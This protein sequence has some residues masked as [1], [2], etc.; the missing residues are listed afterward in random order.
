MTQPLEQACDSGRIEQYLNEQLS[1]PDQVEFEAHLSQ[2]A[3]CQ[4]QIERR[5]AEPELWENAAALLAQS[6]KHEPGWTIA[7]EVSSRH[8]TDES[9]SGFHCRQIQ[10]V[11]ESLSPTDDPEMLGRIDDYEIIGVVGV[12]GMGAVLKGYDK[13]LRR[14]VA[15]KIMAPH[16]AGSGSARMRFQREARAAAAITHHNVIDIYNVS[17]AGGLP[18]LVMPYARGPSLQKRIDEGGPLSVAEVLRIGRQIAAGLAAAHEQGLVHRDIKPANILLNDGIER[19]LITDFGVARAMDDVSMTRTGVIAGT[20]Q[21][22]SP[23]QARGEAVDYR[24]DLFSLGSVLYTACTGRPPFRSEAAYGILRRITDDD[25]RPIREINPDIPDWLCRIINRLMTKH[26]ADRFQNAADLSELLEG[27]LEHLQRPTHV[28]LPPSLASGLSTETPALSDAR[29]GNG[30]DRSRSV[31]LVRT[32][33]WVMVSAFLIAA[34]GL[35]AMQVTAPADIA[36]SWQGDAWTSVTLSSVEEASDWYTG[37]FTAA[38]GQRGA[39]Q[40]EWSRLQ[41]R[42]NGRWKAGD[43]QSGSITLRAGEEGGIRGAVSVDPGATMARET[44]R[45]WEFAWSRAAEESKSAAGVAIQSPVNGVVRWSQGINEGAAVKKG[46]LIAEVRVDDA[47]VQNRLQDQQAAAKQAAADADVR[48]ASNKRSVQAM[49]SL[50]EA[51]ENQLRSYEAVKQQIADAGK[52]AIASALGKVEAAK[53]QIMEDEA[54]LTQL[55]REYERMDILAKGQNISLQK[56]QAAELEYKTAA[57]KVVQSK[58]NLQAIEDDLT[59]KR[60]DATAKETKAQVDVDYAK[61]TLAKAMSDAAKAKDDVDKAQADLAKAQ[62]SI[63]ELSEKIARQ[64]AIQIA[65]PFDGSV[66]ELTGQ[67]II[68]EGARIFTLIPKPSDQLPQKN[69]SPQSVSK[70]QT[71][72]P[73]VSGTSPTPSTQPV[74]ADNPI[75]QTFGPVSDLTR[76]LREGRA[77]VKSLQNDLQYQ[78]ANLNKVTQQ[79]TELEAKVVAVQQNANSDNPDEARKAKESLDQLLQQLDALANQGEAMQATE[80]ATRQALDAANKQ[81][82]DAEAERNTIIQLLRKQLE[83]SGRQLGLQMRLAEIAQ[84]SFE[85]GD[86]DHSNVLRAEQALADTESKAQQLQILAEMYETLDTDP[87]STQTSD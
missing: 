8:Q 35:F 43:G 50:V 86:L 41:R 52:A 30:G 84:R 39:L 69:S 19:L 37:S 14:V 36:G 42:Y 63:K 68:K 61:A 57:A 24:S 32:G 56:F 5:A 64:E 83:A 1:A 82:A 27:C 7:S 26:P 17:D 6:P 16:L 10:S 51:Y 22:M 65:A 70:T 38:D 67:K 54:A 80:S 81:L 2:C 28:A 46:Q 13:S 77:K 11:L 53:Q 45:L 62:K 3:W 12:G 25:P 48:L 73:S 71:P 23:E 75:A 59:E 78:T 18:Y 85:M 15:I 9:D 79:K 87:E 31:F 49:E 76:R 47:N 20:P 58:T 34:F 55:R 74:I 60:S 4:Q 29:L 33:V 44:P 40:L 21:Y 66:T 72:S